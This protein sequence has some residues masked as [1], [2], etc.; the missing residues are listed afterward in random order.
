MLGGN[1]VSAV[2]MWLITLYLVR[3]NNLEEL[4]LLS[5]IQSLGLIFFVFFTFKLLNVQITDNES[6]YT[7]SDYYLA[8]I[9]SCLILVIVSL[10]YIAFLN[11]DLYIK[12]AFISYIFYYCTMIFKEYFS[13]LFQKHKNYKKIFIS[14]SISGFLIFIFFV[15]IFYLTENIIYA[16]LSMCSARLLS[17]CLDHLFISAKLKEIYSSL[18]VISSIHLIKANFF[19]GLSAVFVSSL[20][21][22]PRFYIE[23]YH[24]LK[25]LGVFSALTSIMFFVNIFLNSVTQVFLKDV[26]DIYNKN[27]VLAYKAMISKFSIISLAIGLGLVPFFFLKEQIVLMVFGGKF[28]IYSNEFFYCIFISLF[29]FWFNYGNFILTVQKNFSVQIYISILTFISQLVFCYIFIESYNYIG[30]FISMSVSY[31][32][33]F[34]F[35]CIFFGIKE[36][37]SG[38]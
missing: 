11:Y 36:I 9:L 19:L 21:L 5:L 14:N 33:G 28:V 30:A 32:L 16:V 35:S 22:V 37:K 38:Q 10:I 25:A 13:A 24:G 17:L 15:I 34:I 8:R 23:N 1:L 7:D 20:I 12:L 26:L 6:K 2:F 29:L 4:G 18:N 3:S 31:L 27:K